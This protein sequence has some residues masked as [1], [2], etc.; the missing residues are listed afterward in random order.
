MPIAQ[1]RLAAVARSILA[2]P[3]EV[4]LVVDGDSAPLGD[5]AELRDR[6]GTPVLVCRPG[7]P[8]HRAGRDGRK[9]VL[10]VGSGLG[11]RGGPERD[12]TL[13]LAGRLHVVGVEE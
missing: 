6:R 5:D 10:S 4:N 13:A 8:V 7:S 9:A 2:C 3:A 1:A 11:P 12:D